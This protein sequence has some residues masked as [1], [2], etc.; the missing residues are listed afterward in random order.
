VNVNGEPVSI[1]RAGAPTYDRYGNE[2]PGLDVTI[3]VPGC[4]VAP[5]LSGD[6]TDGGRQGVIVGTTI[7][8]PP[9]TDVRATDRL[10]VRGEEHAIEG[11]PG[12]WVSP[13]TTVEHGVEVAT[14]RVEG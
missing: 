4:A 7:Y 8:F 5:R 9:G 6:V 1:L 11:D 13:W 2:I 3:V 10:V 14:Q 12:R